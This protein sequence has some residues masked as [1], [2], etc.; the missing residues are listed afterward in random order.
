M[1]K[2]FEIEKVPK[3]LDA[4]IVKVK[5]ATVGECIQNGAQWNG[6]L[7]QPCIH[8]EYKFNRD[9][10]EMNREK[11]FTY[12]IEN[13]IKKISELSGLAKYIAKYGHP[14]EGQ[15]VNLKLNDKGLYDLNLA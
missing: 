3:E 13:E 7:N 11:I 8:L 12:R 1:N 5:D 2:E 4:E 14:K 15:K 6:D 9:G 10:K